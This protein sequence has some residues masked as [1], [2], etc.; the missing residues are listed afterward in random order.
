MIALTTTETKRHRL[1]G[2][3]PSTRLPQPFLRGFG[4]TSCVRLEANTT[5]GVV[6]RMGG[7]GA[8]T[9]G[10]DGIGK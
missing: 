8:V 9:G 7:A 5:G 4:Y 1:I 2:G 3:N 6:W 10:S